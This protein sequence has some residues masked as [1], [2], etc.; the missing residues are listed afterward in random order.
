MHTTLPY[1]IVEMLEVAVL[2]R[3]LGNAF[4]EFSIE[5]W[6]RAQSAHAS[7]QMITYDVTIVLESLGA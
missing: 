7:I 3:T 5:V 6:E 1:L 4:S 2:R